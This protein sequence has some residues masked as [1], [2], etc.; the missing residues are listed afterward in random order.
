MRHW[1]VAPLDREQHILY[2]PTLDS[3][4]AADHPV[5]IFAEIAGELD[6][7]AWEAVYQGTLGQPPIHP[8]VM[9]STIIYG[10]SL[11]IRSSRKFEAACENRLDF[12]WLMEGRIPD[13]STFA[14]FRQKFVPQIKDMFKQVVR[15]AREMG[16]VRLNGV[17][18]DGTAIKANNS[19]YNTAK[20]ATIEQ[21]LEALDEQIEAALAEA[22]AQDEAEDRLF[23]QEQSPRKLPRA[24][25]DL[26]KRQEALRKALAKTQQMEQARKGR[27]DLG[28]KDRG[29]KAP[30]ADP[31][32]HVLPNKEGGYAPNYTVV[33]ATDA[34]SGIILNTQVI[35]SNQE[36]STVLP[37]VQQIEEDLGQ[38]PQQILAD[39][40]FNT[41]ANLQDLT[42]AGV[43]PLMPPRQPVPP[44]PARREDPLQPVPAEDYGK[45]PIN[46]QSK[47]LDRSNF[48]FDSGSNRYICPMGR[49]LPQ[50][51]IKPANPDEGRAAQRVYGCQNCAGC[52]LAS[53]CLGK[54]SLS[55][56]VCRDEHEELREAMAA[57][58][59]T[60]QGKQQY[61]RRAPT[62]ETPNASLKTKFN[63]RQFLLRG[64]DLVQHEM[65]YMAMAY[66]LTKIV[67]ARL[68]GL[69][70]AS[71]A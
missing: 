17:G 44:S 42:E 70:P 8:R 55:R 68:V 54:S 51:E 52:P 10:L 20:K 2:S 61:A 66:N 67:A 27:K 11:G 32:S 5:R 24:L 64:K 47:T 53:R 71:P 4:I 21:K 43:E 22:Q 49:L 19:R 9:A 48:I 26:K 28:D 30:L 45:L 34:A 1:A 25:G 16:L 40:G 37:A 29:P 50:V 63:L 56:R 18:M 58:M 14:D 12:K 6:F 59:S 62:C 15:L 3:A 39:S 35:G 46:P 38:K 31:D 36:A 57:R 65:T 41:G 7:G 23:G 33:L 60:E 13:H 69:A